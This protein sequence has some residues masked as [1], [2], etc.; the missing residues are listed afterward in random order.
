VGEV[1]G[2][3]YSAGQVDL[4]RFP[5]RLAR[6]DTGQAQHIVDQP[7]EAV[8]FAVD[9]AHEFLPYSLANISIGLKGLL[10]YSSAPRDS[11]ASRSPY[12]PFVVNIT[13]WISLDSG[14][15]LISLHTLY[16]L[17]LDT[18]TSKI[19]MLGLES[20]IIDIACT[21]SP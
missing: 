8:A 21:P 17:M 18:I 1:Y 10:M 14:P 16:P 5:Y 12:W 7:G 2:G 9:Y 6:L 3:F 15:D 19:R 13:T 20:R 4:G 11:V